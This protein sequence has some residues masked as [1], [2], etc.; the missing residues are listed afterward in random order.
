MSNRLNPFRKMLGVTLLLLALVISSCTRQGRGEHVA[1]GEPLPPFSALTLDGKKYTPETLL[2]QRSLIVFFDTWCPDCK[3]ELPEVQRA[4]DILSDADAPFAILAVSRKSDEKSVKD[5][6]STNSLSIP[7]AVP[8]STSVYDLFDRHSGTGVPQGYL[9]DEEGVVRGFFSDK[10]LVSAGRLCEF[11][12][13]D[14][15][16]KEE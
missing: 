3:D 1:L 12:F 11:L 10:E 15:K 13:V 8:G 7:V 9:V 5:F 4:Y 16:P 14:K 6:W 2:G